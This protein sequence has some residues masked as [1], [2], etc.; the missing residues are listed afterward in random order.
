MKKTKKDNTDNLL[1][2]TE[3]WGKMLIKGGVRK[4]ITNTWAITANLPDAG[5]RGWFPQMHSYLH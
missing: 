2:E 5:Q 3:F 4:G 1:R